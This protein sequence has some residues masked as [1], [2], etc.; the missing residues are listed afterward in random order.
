L[1]RKKTKAEALE[2]LAELNTRSAP[3]TRGLPKRAKMIR[4]AAFLGAAGLIMLDPFDRLADERIVLPLD[5]VCIPAYQAYMIQG[6]PSMQIY[7]RAGETIIPTGGNVQDV[8]EAMEMPDVPTAELHAT[9]RKRKTAYQRAYQ[10][11]FKEI[12][13]KYKMKNG[14]WKKGGFRAAV[15]A[16]HKKAGGKK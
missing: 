2:D 5:M 6:S 14:K 13:P 8:A 4:D 10:K 12:A 7:V 16:A 9:G 3:A 15:K 1:A 11:A